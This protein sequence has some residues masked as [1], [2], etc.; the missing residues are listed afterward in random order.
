MPLDEGPPGSAEAFLK[1][2]FAPFHPDQVPPCS[3]SGGRWTYDPASLLPVVHLYLHVHHDT[4]TAGNGVARWEG[5]GPISWAHVR[6]V[7]GPQA[8]FVIK[9]VIDPA[10]M[11]AVDAYEIPE[12]LREGLHLR[13]PFD[14]FPYA[15]STSRRKQLDHN[16][17]YAPVQN[18]GGEGQTGLHN[19][20]GMTTFH[21]RVKTHGG[22]QVEQ[23]FPGIYVWMSP[24]GSVFVVDNTGTRQLRRP[25]ATGETRIDLGPPGE[26]PMTVRF[27]Q[28]IHDWA[29]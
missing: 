21:H 15:S 10:T 7:L 3:C 25:Q 24:H 9:P 18:G 23:P 1:P 8:R 6:D 14:I 20:G 4:I 28:V 26:S 19:L 5:E 13:T 2:F 17:P 16:R 22:W 12:R 29:A 27:A 11:P